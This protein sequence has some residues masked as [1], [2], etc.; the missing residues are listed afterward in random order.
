VGAT[1]EDAAVRRGLRLLGRSVTAVLAGVLVSGPMANA[2]F[3]GPEPEPRPD[4]PAW[5]AKAQRLAARYDCSPHGLRQGVVPARAVVRVSGKV[6]TVS[7]A[8][9]W[10]TRLGH[11]RGTLVSVCAR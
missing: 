11:Q 4:G 1:F 8:E 7:F 10:A 5:A 3:G 9:G 2:H 6:R